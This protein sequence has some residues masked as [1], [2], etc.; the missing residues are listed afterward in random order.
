MHVPKPVAVKLY[1]MHYT[2]SLAMT[3]I[4]LT[5]GRLQSWLR[6]LYN[7]SNREAVLKY[8]MHFHFQD[9]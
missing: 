9:P 4:Y 1:E 3:V 8:E 5:F 2:G 7:A 6:I